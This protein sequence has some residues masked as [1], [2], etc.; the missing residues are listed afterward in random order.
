M[1]NLYFKY[2]ELIN[3]I[4]FGVATTVV[5]YAVFAFF[6]KVIPIN[7]QIANFI[8]WVISVLFAYITNKLYVFNSKSWE[9]N[10]L[11]KEISSFF[12]ARVVSYFV[13]VI[14]LFIGINL[15]SG[16][17]LIVKLI[18]NIIIVIINYVFS[19]MIIFKNDKG[20]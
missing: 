19:K 8:G 16:D 20:N 6:I 11:F 4:I 5:N 7:Y 15:L 12:T 17:K 1:K 3:Y 2:Q 14:I 10:I 18:D 9:K 13:E